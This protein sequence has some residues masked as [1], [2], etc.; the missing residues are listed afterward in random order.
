M[1]ICKAFSFQ[2]SGGDP[3]SEIQKLAAMFACLEQCGFTVPDFI[4]ASIL[5]IAIPQ[6]WDQILTWLLS[7]YLLDKLKYSVVVRATSKPASSMAHSTVTRALA[8]WAHI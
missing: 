3:T 4:Q 7:Y 2:L 6:K 1:E 5:I 8:L